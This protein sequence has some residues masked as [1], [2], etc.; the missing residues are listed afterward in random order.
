[1]YLTTTT[2]EVIEQFLQEAAST[3]A[4]DQRQN[5][6]YPFFCPVTITP[7]DAA[8]TKLSAFMRN[9][10]R[11]GIG[12]LHNGRL[13]TQLVGQGP[14]VKASEDPLPELSHAR[15]GETIEEFVLAHDDHLQQLGVVRLEVT[16]HA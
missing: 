1:M 13:E 3:M 8:E 5:G 9:I 7:H 15:R 10:S 12:L 11:S 2:D 4:I 6:R 16:D 14:Q